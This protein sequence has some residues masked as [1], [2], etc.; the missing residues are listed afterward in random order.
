M[1]PHTQT[2]KKRKDRSLYCFIFVP[3]PPLVFF[4]FSFSPDLSTGWCPSQDM[5]H[6]RIRLRSLSHCTHGS[7]W[8]CGW[9]LTVRSWHPLH[10]HLLII[11]NIY[12]L[13]L[14]YYF[15]NC[16]WGKWSMTPLQRQLQ[17]QWKGNKCDWPRK[18]KSG[19][20]CFKHLLFTSFGVAETSQRHWKYIINTSL[21]PI[22]IRLK[23]TKIES[24]LYVEHVK[25]IW[26][27]RFTWLDNQAQPELKSS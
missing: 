9:G 18:E 5:S 27:M 16:P 17:L 10:C 25:H 3:Q 1:H 11:W 13:L 19:F 7:V 15:F 6:C 22:T 14:I 20:Q 23:K 24:M 8:G 12:Y 4:V 26:Q 21:I 2:K